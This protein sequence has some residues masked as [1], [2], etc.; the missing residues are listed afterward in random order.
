[1]CDQVNELHGRNSK[2]PFEFS[3]ESYA[4]WCCFFLGLPPVNTLN[5]HVAV[6][7]FDYP[8]QKCQSLHSGSSPFLDATGCHASSNCPSTHSARNRRHNYILRVLA[9]AAKE[10]GLTTRVEPDTYNLLLGDFSQASCKRMFPKRAS[11]LYKERVS[12]VVNAVEVVS[13]PSCVLSDV[14]RR[15]YVQVRI[16]ALPSVAREDA[17]GLRID[18][19]LEDEDTGETKWLD[20]TV[21]H[22]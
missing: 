1:M 13:S 18:V 16:D 17:V 21:V 19:A 15:A 2:T 11:K 6:E 22:T 20:A 12:A 10:A 5:N 8:V 14:E 9:N 4:S 7:C 3:L